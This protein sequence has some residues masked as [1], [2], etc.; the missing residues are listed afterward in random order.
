MT[1]ACRDIANMHLF[2]EMKQMF[3]DLPEDTLRNY[4]FLYAKE[5]DKCVKLL[6]QESQNHFH[7]SQPFTDVYS[8]DTKSNHRKSD[9]LKTSI[10]QQNSPSFVPVTTDLFNQSN[11]MPNESS[12]L[13][14]RQQSELLS[15][16][17]KSHA[18]V[19]HYPYISNLKVPFKTDIHSA[20][21]IANHEKP[22]V[23]MY[24]QNQSSHSTSPQVFSSQ[25]YQNRMMFSTT[26]EHTIESPMM[27]KAELSSIPSTKQSKRHAV[28]L[29]ITPSF[30]F[31]Q[32]QINV[33]NN[34][35]CATASHSSKPGRHTTSL[36][37]QLQPQSSDQSPI[38]IST[39]PTNIQD[40]CNFRD[41]G[42]HVQISVGAQ[43]ATFTALRLQRPQ[44]VPNQ[45]SKFS[46]PLSPEHISCSTASSQPRDSKVYV[47]PSKI[48]PNSESTERNKFI[49]S[50]N[51]GISKPFQDPAHLYDKDFQRVLNTDS[52]RRPVYGYQLS[53]EYV[54]A[55][56]LHQKTSLSII[57]DELEKDKVI[58]SQLLSEVNRMEQEINEQRLK[59]SSFSYAEE[60][61]LLREENRKLRIECNCLLMEVDMSSNTPSVTDEDFY[62]NIFTG[63]NGTI[64]S[65]SL[66]NV[67][68]LNLSSKNA[69]PAH[70]KEDDDDDEK[71][72]WRCKKCTFANYPALENCEMCELPRNS[73]SVERNSNYCSTAYLTLV[74]TSNNPPRRP[75]GSVQ[76]SVTRRAPSASKSVKLQLTHRRPR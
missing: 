38:E 63:P 41:F 8:S 72:R 59:K 65:L 48:Q 43:G 57:E 13:Y 5:Y 4:V 73:G 40:P 74:P 60:L 23:D 9:T 24:K 34:T 1:M 51:H 17:S 19:P 54:E 11:K 76:I 75:V 16:R 68:N 47:F 58:C 66:R 22:F 53:Q 62:S 6:Q 27:P 45:Q 67:P 56:K 21:V 36:N 46:T 3:P 28:E 61:K 35:V 15:G 69:M 55:L 64:S 20:P 44:S 31:Q 29:S 12:A 70:K 7:Q 71:N 42:S 2:L 10:H 39:I 33:V 32:Q 14:E 18:G 26:K 50:I 52:E 37:F 25:D 49:K 30:P